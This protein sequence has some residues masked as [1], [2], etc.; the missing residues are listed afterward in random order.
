[1]DLLHN[2]PQPAECMPG[3]VQVILM[4]PNE[5]ARI[6]WVLNHEKILSSSRLLGQKPRGWG[7]PGGGIEFIDA[8][9]S[10][11]GYYYPTE[12]IVRRCAIR[13]VRNETGFA[14]F[15]FAHPLI[16]AFPYFRHTNF[17]GHHRYTTMATLYDLH[18][19]RAEERESGEIED[20][21]WFDISLSPVEQFQ[22]KKDL[23]YWSHL[24]K[25]LCSLVYIARKHG[26]YLQIHPLWKLALPLGKRDPRF[27]AMGYMLT[28][29]LWKT[30]FAYHIS[31][32][33]QTI[34]L[35]RIY[36]LYRADIDEVRTYQEHH[37]PARSNTHAKEYGESYPAR[38]ERNEQEWREFGEALAAN[39][40]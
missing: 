15:Q 38:L 36:R 5:Q 4:H 28:P 7:N 24:K 29:P 22:N 13:E 18:Q 20:G 2:M 17:S 35:D 11:E 16:P 19:T 21:S 3:T 10:P 31:R 9:S 37:H 14:R 25:T 1:M 40:F 30:E 8:L 26:R 32:G 12:E 6:Y 27:P 23:P 33:R 34:D 39:R